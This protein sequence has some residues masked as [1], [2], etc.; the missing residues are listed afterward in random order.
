MSG[1]S[2]MNDCNRD[3]PCI[4]LLEILCSVQHHR[5]NPLPDSCQVML[6]PISNKHALPIRRFHQIFQGI[7]LPVMYVFY[8]SV[9]IIDRPVCHLHQLVG[10]SGGIYRINI[11]VLI[12]NQH[13]FLKLMV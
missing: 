10:Q 2:R 6:I 8:C 3:L 9:L 1:R 5:S 13:V 7:Q 4:P 12:W 11:T